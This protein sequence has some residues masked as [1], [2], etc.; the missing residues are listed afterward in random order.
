MQCPVREVWFAGVCEWSMEVHA[1]YMSD[2]FGKEAS[3][4]NI[5]EVKMCTP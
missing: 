3:K 4:I 2:V 1:A 5:I